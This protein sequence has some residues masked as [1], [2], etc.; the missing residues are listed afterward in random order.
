MSH[1]RKLITF[2]ALTVLLSVGYLTAKLA[3]LFLVLLTLISVWTLRKQI[4][5][6]QNSPESIVTATH[7]S[8]HTEDT[9]AHDP[10][11][12]RALA[13]MQEQLSLIKEESAQV[14]GLIDKAIT[15]LSACFQKLNQ[16]T[17]AQ[18]DMLKTSYEEE[19]QTAF[20]EFV[21]ETRQ[22][23][24]YLVELIVNTSKDSVYLMHCLD[25]MSNRVNSVLSLL[26][27]VK[28]VASD[29]N[30]LSLNA[31]I[32]AARAGEAGKGFSVVAQEVRNL[33]KKSDTINN[34]IN[35]ISEE[36]IQTLDGVRN[37]VNRIASADM[38]IALN[39]KQ[40]V[41]TMTQLMQDKNQTTNQVFE[42]TDK[43]SKGI[44]HSTESAIMALQFEDMCRQL[45]EHIE[46]RVDASEELIQLADRAIAGSDSGDLDAHL[47]DI[48]TK[49]NE[50]KP[51]IQSV[52][53]KSVTQTDM[54]AGEVE[55][56]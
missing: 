2:V 14:R 6:A 44:E 32:E 31:S 54:N 7:H 27:D 11:N 10:T 34:D 9:G 40:K 33:S 13:D 24:D 8:Q 46:K 5:Q 22:L 21:E 50:L 47:V 42:E 35:T 30:L 3:G 18:Q 26:N 25:D 12:A 48:E 41:T 15:E 28:N 53:H 16:G 52:Q 56:F 55:L 38:N 51:K 1:L 49:L 20:N 17:R 45:L 29:I 39:S 37:V 23:L 36:V 4:F 19:H 43:I